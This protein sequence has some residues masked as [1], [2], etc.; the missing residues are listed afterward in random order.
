MSDDVSTNLVLNFSP[1]HLDDVEVQVGIVEYQGREHLRTLRSRHN[2]THVFYR[3]EGTRIL[4]VPIGG[5]ATS[6]GAPMRLH[7][8]YS[9]EGHCREVAKAAPNLSL[10]GGGG[11]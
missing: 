3:E 8:P 10:K 7:C 9:K 5:I 2:A 11:Q 4:C 1:V 6:A